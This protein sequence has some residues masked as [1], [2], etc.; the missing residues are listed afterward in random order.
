MVRVMSESV[1]GGLR[2]IVSQMEKSFSIKTVEGEPMEF[3][4]KIIIPFVKV[5]F[6]AG[7]APA[8]KRGNQK[9][10]LSIAAAWDSESGVERNRSVSWVFSEV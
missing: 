6:G 5:S 4:D 2:D 8:G 9:Q 10:P 7:G 3:E 1:L